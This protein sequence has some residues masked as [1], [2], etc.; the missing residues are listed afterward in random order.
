MCACMHVYVCVWFF[1]APESRF[2]LSPIL[3]DSTNAL[4]LFFP[5]LSIFLFLSLSLNISLL[6]PKFSSIFC[7]KSPLYVFLEIQIQRPLRVRG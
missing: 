5:I 1:T 2:L 4:I 3:L 7:P 6:F